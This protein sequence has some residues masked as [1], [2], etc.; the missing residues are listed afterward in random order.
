MTVNEI[1]ANV[2]LLEPN[3]CSAEEKLRWL[4]SLDGKIFSE[5]ILAHERERATVVRSAAEPQSPAPGDYWY[6]TAETG[7][8][9]RR[10]VG[11]GGGGVWVTVTADLSYGML[12]GRFDRYVSGKETPLIP[13]PYA[14][15]VYTH[16]LIAMIAAANAE[17]AR[18]NQQI[19]LYNAEYAQWWNAY[20]AAKAPLHRGTRFVF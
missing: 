11:F 4:S 3:S 19:A 16:Y 7:H 10:F 2:D 13:F 12:A 18:Y 6:E 5:V 1:I 15:D 20:H 17:T 14:E 8:V 9:L